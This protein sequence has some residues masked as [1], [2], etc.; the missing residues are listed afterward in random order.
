MKSLLF[1]NGCI[2]EEESR[3]LVLARRFL[4]CLEG[5]YEISEVSGLSIPLDRTALNKRDHLASQ[6]NWQDPVFNEARKFKEADVVV[7]AA[8]FWEGTFPAAVH[9]YL[10]Q[11]CVTGL[12]FG[13]DEDG[14][15]V[16][17]C[18]AERAVFFSTRGGIYSEGENK[19]DD[20]AEKFLTS[21]FEMLGIAATDTVT[22]EGLDIIGN[23]VD[24]LMDQASEQAKLL[25][26][27]FL[28]LIA[29][30]APTRRV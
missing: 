16:G 15:A 29:Q 28:Y 22:A 13:Y 11:I 3:T 26:E 12:T 9:A 2:R 23:D 25:A 24:F 10:E 1:I 6:K 5:T 8:P 14:R 4:D 19:K 20:H 17:Y 21:I 27:S 30:S 18:K 7:L